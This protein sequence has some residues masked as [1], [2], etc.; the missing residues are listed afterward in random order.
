MHDVGSLSGDFVTKV[1][2][3]PDKKE[4]YSFN[5]LLIDRLI[6]IREA[7]EQV[8]GIPLDADSSSHLYQ[9]LRGDIHQVMRMQIICES[10]DVKVL[11][12]CEKMGLHIKEH[13]NIPKL[14]T[15]ARKNGSTINLSKHQK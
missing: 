7:I 11:L 3:G 9:S 15:A 4:T 6:Y 1:L 14:N 8:H 2:D 10:R 12:L 5:E 13:E